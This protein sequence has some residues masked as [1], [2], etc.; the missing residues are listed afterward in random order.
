MTSATQLDTTKFAAARLVALEI[1]PFLGSALFALSP[2]VDTR[3]GTF[4]VDEALHLYVDPTCLA[5]WSV[6]EVA[7][8]LLHEVGHVIRDHAGRAKAALV[9]RSNHT[10]WNVAAD[11]EI[12]DD[13]RDERVA[14]PGTPVYPERLGLPRHRVA[15]FYFAALE[16]KSSRFD[17]DCGSGCHGVEDEDPPA[18]P[19][20]P[21]LTAVDLLLLRRQIAEAVLTQGGLARGDDP[22]GWARWAE[23]TLRPKIDWRPLL[24]SAIRGGVGSTAG[25]TDYSYMRPSRRKVP[26][27]VLPAMRKTLPRVSIV[28]DTSGSVSANALNQAW[29]ETLSCVRQVGVRRDLI[30][31][32][33][34]DASATHIRRP[35][36]RQVQLTGGGG[37]DMSV[38]IAAAC[39][40]QPTPTLIVVLTD[41]YTPWP[42][43]APP[44]RVVVALL[45]GRPTHVFEPPSWAT[46]VVVEVEEDER[47]PS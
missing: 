8:V 7:G 37:T 10:R 14:L 19:L 18:V 28:I 2:V 3:K 29:A 40:L 32:F 39:K 12:N 11:A 30:D 23:A 43:V 5:K 34:V 20:V 16:A 17:V 25:M 33:A 26:K 45:G 6:K 15:E 42:R 27:V 21:G 4:A 24:K 35:H 1:Q 46:T 31:V 44:A 47:W 36:S 13:L 41:G 22:G 38:G 9:D